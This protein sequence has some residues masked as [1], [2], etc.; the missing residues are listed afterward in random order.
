M[1]P[2]VKHCWQYCLTEV[3]TSAPNLFVQ[4]EREGGMR[5]SDAVLMFSI[6]FIQTRVKWGSLKFNLIITEIIGSLSPC[7]PYMYCR[8]LDVQEY[9]YTVAIIM[10]YLIRVTFNNSV[11]LLLSLTSYAIAHLYL[12]NLY[13]LTEL[14]LW[15]TWKYLITYRQT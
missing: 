12:A 15:S 1:E 11:N 7:E 3:K 10:S 5:D 9:H 13:V 8:I 14:F 4:K 2:E 6:S